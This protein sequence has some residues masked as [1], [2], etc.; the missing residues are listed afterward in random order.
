MSAEPRQVLLVEDE[1]LV[2][3]L[4]ADMLADL[5]CALA[6]SADRLDEALVLA[7]NGAFD[8]ALLDLRLRGVATYPV[9]DVLKER[10]IPFAFVTGHRTLDIDPAY[11]DIPT[12]QKPFRLQDLAA[13]IALLTE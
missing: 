8:F 5:G 11:A 6:A 12:L 2:G 10:R 9:A 4:V 7:R 13:A 1:F 3:M